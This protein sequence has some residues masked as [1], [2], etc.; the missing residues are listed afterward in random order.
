MHRVFPALNPRTFLLLFRLFVI[1]FKNFYFHI[2]SFL[3][4]H[5]QSD[6]RTYVGGVAYDIFAIFKFKVITFHIGRELYSSGKMTGE[7]QQHHI[8]PKQIAY[9]DTQ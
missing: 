5:R 2:L 9:K 8:Q 7:M 4:R 6:R 1:E 3:L